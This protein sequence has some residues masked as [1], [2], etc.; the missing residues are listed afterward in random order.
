MSVLP[1]LKIREGIP[2]CMLLEYHILGYLPTL[3]WIEHV[4]F[5]DYPTL[6]PFEN[7]QTNLLP[8]NKHNL[9]TNNNNLPRRPAR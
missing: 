6:V 9:Q 4:E 8:S 2:A 5:Q 3:N 1:S 7:I